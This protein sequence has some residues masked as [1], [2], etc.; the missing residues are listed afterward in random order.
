MEERK[1]VFNEFNRSVF[2]D[3]LVFIKRAEDFRAERR[4]LRRNKL[5]KERLLKK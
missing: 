4:K 1:D 2:A 5:R 3:V